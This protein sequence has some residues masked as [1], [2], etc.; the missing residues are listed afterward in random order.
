MANAEQILVKVDKATKASMKRANINWSAEIR[1]FIK[2]KI[3]EQRNLALAVALTDKI[4][5]S[6]KKHKSDIAST[7]RKFRDERYGEGSG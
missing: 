4:F 1:E 2:E 6:Q 3:N 5:N 7:I